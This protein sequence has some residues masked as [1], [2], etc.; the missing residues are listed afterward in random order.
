MLNK[1]SIQD[2]QEIAT[3]RGGRCLSSK[4]VNAH[5]KLSWICK[6]KHIGIA[7]P[8]NIIRGHW[9]PT[10][11]GQTKLTIQE[12]QK[13][14]AKHGGYCLSKKYINAHT[15]LKWQCDKGHIWEAEPTGIKHG[16]VWCKICSGLAP[17]TIQKMHLIAAKKGGRCLSKKY[18]NSKTKLRW[19]CANGHEWE[20]IPHH[21]NRNHW[22]PVCNTSNI[23]ESFTRLIFQRIFEKDFPKRK[24]EWLTNKEGQY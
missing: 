10:C 17:L 20:A 5:Y 6:E 2:M 15:K 8:N 11:A 4:Y 18:I 1:L 9:C 16:D 22:C 23:N 7:E 3:R 14:A 21:I 24:P 12:M 13:I 19:R